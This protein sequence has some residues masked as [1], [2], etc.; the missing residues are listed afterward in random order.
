M[1]GISSRNNINKLSLNLAVRAESFCRHFFPSGTKQGNYWQI[2]D[3]SGAK[4]QSLAIRL[5]DHGQG[6]A[7]KWTDYA[8]GEY[9]DLIDLLHANRGGSF[10]DTLNDCWSF[11]G[12]T[13]DDFD[14][15]DNASSSSPAIKTNENIGNARKLFKLG[16]S[17]YKTLGS[18]YLFGRGIKRFG[19]AL[20]FHPSVYVR[21]DDQSE[22][23]QHPALLA[24]VT[25]NDGVITGVARTFLNP[26]TK[27]L[28]EFKN[29]KRALG[30]L[31]GNAIR[32]GKGA[33]SDDLI[34]GEGMENVLSIGTVLPDHDLAS[35]L[36]A[37]HLG[38]FQ[39]PSNIKRLWIARDN[40][41]AGEMA[42]KRL[43][44]TAEK[45]DIWVGDIV[46]DSGD[47][48][49]DL[50]TMGTEKFEAFIISQMT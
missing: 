36:T 41:E 7:G 32:F 25:N 38:L 21:P 9:G 10:K 48:N 2:G 42:A 16:K 49:D 3:T 17:T 27:G 6:R 18:A 31:Y 19:P 50:E 37:N 13:P 39:P 34:V 26:K 14:A 1:R 45:M 47:F 28:A 46:P 23:Q 35:C 15:S 11:L 29:P 5:S 8:S 12:E 24:K 43:R 44:Q 40:D 20:K 33:Y 4:G 30:Q 22:V